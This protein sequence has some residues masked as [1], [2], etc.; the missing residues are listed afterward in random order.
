MPVGTGLLFLLELGTADSAVDSGG[1]PPAGS[2]FGLARI[3]ST[4]QQTSSDT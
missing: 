1:A 4:S 3:F 2:R